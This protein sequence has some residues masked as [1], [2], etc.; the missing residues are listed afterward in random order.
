[1]LPADANAETMTSDL[2]RELLTRDAGYGANI[3]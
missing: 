1:M 3:Y 2:Y